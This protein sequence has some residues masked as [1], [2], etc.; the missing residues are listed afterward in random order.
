VLF[1][2]MKLPVVGELI[3][4]DFVE[5]FSVDGGGGKV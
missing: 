3:F 1:L 2:L 4:D 5:L